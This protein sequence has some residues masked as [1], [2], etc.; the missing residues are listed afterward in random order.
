MRVGAVAAGG[1]HE[2]AAGKVSVQMD[3]IA[4][5]ADRRGLRRRG[6]QALDAEPHA[7][8]IEGGGEAHADD[9]V[10]VHVEQGVARHVVPRT[11]EDRVRAG[12]ADDRVIAAAGDE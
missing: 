2:V 12:A 6:E 10:A 3:R 8:D 11:E 4:V 7:L 9:D 5:L 1:D